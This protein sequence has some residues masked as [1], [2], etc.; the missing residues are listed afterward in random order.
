MQSEKSLP[1]TG[2]VTGLQGSA[3]ILEVLFAL[4]NCEGTAVSE[5]TRLPE[6]FSV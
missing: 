2:Q 6:T 3:D 5:R 4:G 1:C